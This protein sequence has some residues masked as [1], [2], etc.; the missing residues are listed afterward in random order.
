MAKIPKKKKYS[1]KKH[2]VL[3]YIFS[4][5]N[6]EKNVE[7]EIISFTLEDI[8]EGY[9]Q[10]GIPEP[11]SISNTIL[12]LVRK[13]RAINS[14]L[15]KSIYELGYDLRKKTGVGADGK[16]YAGEFVYVGVGNE[17]NSW[18]EW[19]EQYDN[20]IV[21]PSAGIPDGI[22]EFI[23][24]DEGALFSV[25]DYCDVFSKVFYDRP[26]TVI[27]IQNPLK[28]QPNE[29]DGFYFSNENNQI[30]L[31][32]VEA[33]ALTTGDD[34]NLEQTQGALRVIS[35]RYINRDIVIKPLAVKMINNGI[36]IAEF[37]TVRTLNNDNPQ[38]TPLRFHKIN[39]APVIDTWH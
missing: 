7:I 19:P 16:S 26:N 29:I 31:Y 34:I 4:K 24:S 35:Q 33:K 22:R 38:L 25:I 10:V 28:W 36:L 11:A 32:P 30:H 9:K 2:P 21:L 37:E 6:P 3:E 13:K 23:R 5:K 12:D 14:R 27:R 15:P 1:S 20:E 18:L 39:F 17:I 8:S